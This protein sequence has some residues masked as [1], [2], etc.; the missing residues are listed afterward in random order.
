MFKLIVAAS[1][2]VLVRGEGHMPVQPEM[3]ADADG[4]KTNLPGGMDATVSRYDRKTADM[5]AV[6][7]AQDALAVDLKALDG[8]V[9]TLASKLASV[10]NGI[11]QTGS[12]TKQIDDAQFSVSQAK[13]TQASLAGAQARAYAAQ[14]VVINNAIAKMESDADAEIATALKAFDSQIIAGEKDFAKTIATLSTAENKGATLTKNAA[15]IEAQ[16]KLHEGCAGKAQIYA[17]GKCINADI[18]STSFIP[19]ISHHMFNNADGRDSGYISDR[20]M[21]FTKH[22]DESYLRIFWYDNLRV[23]GHTA[24]GRWNIYMCDANG[25][26]CAECRNPGRL[27][28]WK[29]SGHQHNWWMNDHV[30]HVISGLCKATSNRE[31]KKGTYQMKI[32]L[33]SNRYDMYT[34]HNQAGSFMVDEVMKY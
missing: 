32:Y 9:K 31:L 23:H 5:D 4:I 14:Q 11:G 8:T 27:N 19:K 28:A 24:H 30:G 1:V 21:K 25:N 10:T 34:G 12:V 22:V 26:G 20:V 3:Y 7:E 29:W 16:L 2:A 15:A 17:S 18:P 6:T 13:D 33:H